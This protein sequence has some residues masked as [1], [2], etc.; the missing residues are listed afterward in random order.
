MSGSA[1][2]FVR[3]NM[4]VRSDLKWP[5]AQASSRLGQRRFGV[6]HNHRA[7]GLVRGFGPTAL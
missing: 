7:F 2:L 4:S 6:P 3:R 1:F 5:L